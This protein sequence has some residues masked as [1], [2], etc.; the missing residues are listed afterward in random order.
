MSCRGSTKCRDM[1]S[2]TAVPPKQKLG[3]DSKERRTKMNKER[4]AEAQRRRKVSK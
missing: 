4:M 3:R 1:G 2:G